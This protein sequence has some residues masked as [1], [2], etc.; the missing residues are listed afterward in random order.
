MASVEAGAIAKGHSTPQMAGRYAR[1]VGAK[2]LALWHFSAKYS[3]GGDADALVIMD[4]IAALAA[5][6]CGVG[7]TA[8]RDLMTMRLGVK[9]ELEVVAP[10]SEA[11]DGQSGRDE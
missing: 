11:M 3:G 10:P 1:A 4:E 9:G 7:V 6:E 5:G 8:T 2:H